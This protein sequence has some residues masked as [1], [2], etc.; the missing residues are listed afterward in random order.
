[1]TVEDDPPRR[2]L[3]ELLSDAHA[4][5]QSASA[6][7]VRCVAEHSRRLVRLSHSEG[8]VSPEHSVRLIEARAAM[9][10]QLVEFERDGIE[11][12]DWRDA[13]AG[14]CPKCRNR[15]G[16]RM[17]IAQARALLRTEFCTAGR[18]KALDDPFQGCRCTLVPFV[19]PT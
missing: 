3:R 2:T 6:E 18:T 1:M 19:L 12:V 7:L 9:L 13:G 4:R 10:E 8:G 11:H 15:H 17:T 14:Q 16:R 5:R